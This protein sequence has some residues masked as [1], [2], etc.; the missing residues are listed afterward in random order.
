[1]DKL[2]E[3]IIGAA[4]EVHRALGPGLLESIYAE[5]LTQELRAAGLHVDRELQLP[6]KYKGITLQQT[7]RL[8]ILVE[9]SIILECKS[10]AELL[11]VHT[12]QLLTYLRLSERKLGLLLNFNVP[13]MRNGIKR[14]ANQ[15]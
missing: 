13:A 15:L 10:V 2:S 8:D 3:K 7:M 9:D 14:V 1:M 4:I 6:V 12:A 5:S 11:P